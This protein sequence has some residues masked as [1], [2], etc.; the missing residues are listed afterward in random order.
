[1]GDVEGL[2]EVVAGELGLRGVVVVDIWESS[3]G[4]EVTPCFVASVAVAESGDKTVDIP[5]GAL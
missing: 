4:D 5:K 3:L 2:V 1:M